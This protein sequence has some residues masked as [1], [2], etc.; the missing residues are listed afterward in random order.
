ME[1]YGLRV[2]TVPIDLP[3]V[4]QELVFAF[5]EQ[6]AADGSPAGIAARSNTPPMHSSVRASS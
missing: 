4:K 5:A 3:T 1:L 6:R 2:E